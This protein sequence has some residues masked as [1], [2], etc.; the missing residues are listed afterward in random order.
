[1][2]R[3]RRRLQ[4]NMY[5]GYVK[6][7]WSKDFEQLRQNL[8]DKVSFLVNTDEKI[9]FSVEEDKLSIIIPH[10]Q[11][12]VQKNAW[13]DLVNKEQVI[14]I[15]G[16]GQKAAI[17]LSADEKNENWIKMLALEPSIREY[18]TIREMIT[19]SVYNDYL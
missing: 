8:R 2:T 7:V 11:N 19:N 1:M 18:K 6:K 15:F 10:L 12:S 4:F 9:V 3:S 13:H 5:L 16:D 17:P 14:A